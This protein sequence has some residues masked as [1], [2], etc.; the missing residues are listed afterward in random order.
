[1]KINWKVRFNRENLQFN[2]RFIAAL[3]IPILAYLGYRL[4]DIITWNLVKKIFFDFISNPYLIFLTVYNAMN[5][6]P[7]PTT[8]GI[9]DSKQALTYS[10][11]KND[12]DYI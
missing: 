9:S 12:N 6:V 11:P 8:S 4:D 10:K 1:M 5:I 2:V 3:V 7:D